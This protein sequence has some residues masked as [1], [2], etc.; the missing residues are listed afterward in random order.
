[1]SYIFGF[2]YAE[3][4]SICTSKF[5]REA[6]TIQSSKLKGVSDQASL[7]YSGYVANVF[8][9]TCIKLQVQY[10]NI[11]ILKICFFGQP[12]RMSWMNPWAFCP[13]LISAVGILLTTEV[14][15]I[16]HPSSPLPP[17]Y[18]LPILP[19]CSPS[20]SCHVCQPQLYCIWSD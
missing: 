3:T 16:F 11:T 6:I 1:M 14:Q 4:E 18:P 9:D 20:S 19:F 7:C 13:L 8:K 17:S 10:K 2:E 5:L 12:M 15:S